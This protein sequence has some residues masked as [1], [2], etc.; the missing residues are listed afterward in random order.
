MKRSSVIA[1]SLLAVLTLAAP[2]GGS[3]SYASGIMDCHIDFF[4]GVIT[5]KKCTPVGSISFTKGCYPSVI[6]M[7]VYGLAQNV[8]QKVTIESVCSDVLKGTTIIGPS[9]DPSVAPEGAVLVSNPVGQLGDNY[10]HFCPIPCGIFGLQPGML[11]WGEC[12]LQCE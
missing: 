11:G 1:L 8:G 4:N 9:S 10:S 5:G 12:L 6:Q 3:V 2:I 7:I